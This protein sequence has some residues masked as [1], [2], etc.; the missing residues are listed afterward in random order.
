MIFVALYT[1]FALASKITNCMLKFW[2]FG[3]ARCGAIDA[4]RHMNKKKGFM[5]ISPWNISAT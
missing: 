3:H 4:V 2:G 1:W 5:K